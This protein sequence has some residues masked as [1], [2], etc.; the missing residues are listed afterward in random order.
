MNL[1]PNQYTHP[2]RFCKITG[3]PVFR[4]NIYRSIKAKTFLCVCVGRDAR[5]ALKVARQMFILERTAFARRES[6]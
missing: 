5:H 1:T 6:Q 4:F 2:N 3:K